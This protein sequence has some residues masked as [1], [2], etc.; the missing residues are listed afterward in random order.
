M[1]NPAMKAGVGLILIGVGLMIYAVK[2][3]RK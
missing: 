3:K 1:T 2:K